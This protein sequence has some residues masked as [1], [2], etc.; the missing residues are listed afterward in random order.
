MSDVIAVESEAPVGADQCRAQLKRIVSS[1]DFE[2]TE[3]EHRFLSYVVEEVLQGRGHRIK[4]YSIAVE[5]FGREA[6][7]DAQHDPIVRIAAGHLR[8]ALERYYLTGGKRDPVRIDIPKGSYVPKFS[9]LRM[10]HASISPAETV[11]EGSVPAPAR[12][13]SASFIRGMI[14]GLTAAAL[15]VVAVYVALP[16][17]GETL[18]SK[19]PELPRVYV[20][21]LEDITR[22]PSSSTI[23][24]GLTQ[25]IVTHLSRFRD[26][27]VLQ[28]AHAG[29]TVDPP[30]RFVLAGSVETSD[31]DFHLRVRLVNSEDG[32]ILWA[33]RFDGELR[34]SKFSRISRKR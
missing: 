8:R 24:N 30:A 19:S 31:K 5:V 32:S 26:I 20:T 13:G 22:S 18:I 29:A 10:V 16:I 15:V 3:R 25:E 12:M 33:N 6:S 1:T 34:A 28:S 27:T 23:A 9:D 4:A 14:G 2:A 11:V 21:A 17:T 7:F